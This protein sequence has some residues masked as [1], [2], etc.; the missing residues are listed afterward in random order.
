MRLPNLFILLFIVAC[1]SNTET[2]QS[3]ANI[4]TVS[5]TVGYP[6]QNGLIT[7]E[8]YEGVQPTAFD[9]LQLNEDYTFSKEVEIQEPGY[10]RL[11]F[12][13]IQYVPLILYQDD[14]RVNVDGNAQNG[15][16]DIS[17]SSDHD[18]ITEAQ[19]FYQQSL[20]SPEV[21]QI[22]QAFREASQQQDTEAMDSL[23]TV[24]MKKDEAIKQQIMDQ[25]D[26]LG[27]S[28]GVVEILRNGR[29][30]DKD[31]HYELY[32]GYADLIEEEMPHSPIAMDFV[33]EVNEMKKLAVGQVAPDIALPNPEGEVVKL[34][35]LR[36]NYVLVD[37]WAKWCKPCR[38]EN[39][40]VVRLYNK[41]NAQGFEV[42]GVSLDRRKEDWVQAIEEDGLHWTQVSDLKFWN[43]E[44]ARIYN[45]K[46]IPFAVLLDPE[47]KIIGKNLR[48][49]ALENKLGEIFG[50]EG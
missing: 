50:E 44:A 2:G 49:Q 32:T 25:I 47:G 43:S 11:N 41:Y 16:S 37:F 19:Q 4:I 15:Y 27:P 12:Y 46:A 1:S 7:L 24:Y 13:D 28:L 17:G 14:I 18:F 40:N 10:Y 22:N 29:I 48:G 31:K 21:Q 3:D 23:R 30:F 8:K 36:G 33:N 35:S 5:G 6:Q 34:S 42:Y 45:I 20:S 26:S 38:M 39:P 9:T